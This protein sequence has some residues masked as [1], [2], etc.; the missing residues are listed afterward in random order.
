MQR[1]ADI[2]VSVSEDVLA[3]L[4]RVAR[5]RGMRRAHVLRE[6]I[7]DYLRR[8][9]LEG[10][11]REMRDYAEALA[12]FSA[13]FVKETDSHTVQQLLRETEW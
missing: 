11:E 6:A 13:E 3:G 9:E 8:T 4:D 10:I 1:T 7:V 12:P 5:Q 2:H